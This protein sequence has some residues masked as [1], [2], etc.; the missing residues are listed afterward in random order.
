MSGLGAIMAI[1]TKW[2][3]K[4]NRVFN[5]RPRIGSNKD[6][7]WL[8]RRHTSQRFAEAFECPG[9]HVCLDG[10][11]GAGKTSLALT[12]LFNQGISH[13]AIQLTE[14]MDWPEFC[15][16]I[17]GDTTN[18]ETSLSG[19]MEVGMDKALPVAKFRICLGTKNRPSDKLTYDDKL[20][21]V[22]TE[23]DV[24]KRLCELKA[25]LYVDDVERANDK[26]LSRLSDLCKLLT[27]SYV[28]E[29]AKLIFVGSGKIFHG[30]YKKNPSLDERLLQ[31]SLGAFENRHDSWRFLAK[32]FEK[33]RVRHPG[34]SDFAE[35]REQLH[36]CI[37]SIWE[38]ADGLPKS[39]NRLGYDIALKAEGRKG[40]SYS[41]ILE[42]AHKMSENHWI[43]Y[44]HTFSGVVGFLEKTPEAV[45]FIGYLYERGIARIHRFDDIV[46]H[47]ETRGKKEG[48]TYT[49]NEI[50]DV[51]NQLLRFDFLVR[52]GKSGEIIFTKHPAAAHTLG[53]VMRDPSRFKHLLDN[54]QSKQQPWVQ[55]AFPIQKELLFPDSENV[56]G[57]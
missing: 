39:L 46:T 21:H 15:H 38:A 3:E 5:T 19:D 37:N 50:D 12:Y 31:V 18:A 24:A 9:A 7:V 17:I 16:L 57:G 22:M 34:N 27:Q 6:T 51:I 53:V 20:A 25:T 45:A 40:V 29:N 52:T 30:L 13:A 11:S 36:T 23:H 55:D 49:S 1:N 32:G 43:E 42:D 26:L 56:V 33:L 44:G 10:P 54:P 14:N 47:L 35:Q 28:A 8:E 41:D 4:V 2:A 48:R